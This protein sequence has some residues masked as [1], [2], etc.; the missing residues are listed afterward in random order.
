MIKDLT[1]QKFSRLTAIKMV[2]KEN[3]R[4]IW[5]CVC[6]CGNKCKVQSTSLISGNTKSCG[7]LSKD[8]HKK[9]VKDLLGQQ[10]G[11]LKVLSFKGIEKHKAVWACECQCGNKVDVIGRNLVSG[12]TQSCG[13][14][15][16]EIAGKKNINNLS[17]KIFGR[18]EVVE[19][20]KKYKR[21]GTFYRCICSCGK[22]VIVGHGQL[23]TGQTKSCG[24]LK[25]ELVRS[26]F[27]T[28]GQ[29]KEKL[30]KVWKSMRK[31][32]NNPHDKSYKHYGALGIKVCEE[33]N[34]Y[35]PFRKWAYENG[36]FEMDTYTRNTIDRIN[37]YGDYCP[38]NCRIA[39]WF[40]QAHNKRSDYGKNL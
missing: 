3:H 28:H 10:F 6:E 40:I 30:Y 17:G 19:R 7:C 35:P 11:R 1:G 12:I 34:T 13:C 24:C 39:D 16:K 36:Y 29:S 25:K 32:C 23:T 20:L 8:I 18:L 31:R 21:K 26:Q 9:M 27:S 14:Y 33:W 38:E 5:E 22:E 15:Q 37:P 4:V 2:G